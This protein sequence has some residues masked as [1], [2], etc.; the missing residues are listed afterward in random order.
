MLAR[1]ARYAN[2]GFD[3]ICWLELIVRANGMQP[4]NNCMPR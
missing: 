3:P 2:V 1:A 4:R